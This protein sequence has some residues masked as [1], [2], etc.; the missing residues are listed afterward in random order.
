MHSSRMRTVC[1]S[2]RL[3]GGVP[4]HK[5]GVPGHGGSTWSQGEYLVTG[6]GVPGH[7]GCTWSGTPLLLTES[8]TGVKT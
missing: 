2:G 3:R 6:G 4:G 1:S 5:G 7:G 8:Q